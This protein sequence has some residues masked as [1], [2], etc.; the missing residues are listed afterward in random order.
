MDAA[1]ATACRRL[2]DAIVAD[3]N[4]TDLGT[5]LEDIA[6]ELCNLLEVCPDHT[7][8]AAICRDDNLDCAAGRDRD[9]GDDLIRTDYE[10]GD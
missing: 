5:L 8:D 3:D 7:T 4:V 9:L 6:T 2:A 10:T 1:T